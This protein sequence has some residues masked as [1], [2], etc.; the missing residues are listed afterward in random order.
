MKKF[1][2]ILGL[3]FLTAV[4]L[5][6]AVFLL[7]WKSPKYYVAK[8]SAPA[9]YLQF[10]NYKANH[11]KPYIIETNNL[12]IFGAEH[13]RDPKDS[14]IKPIKDKWERLQPTVALVEGRLGFLLPMFMDPVEKLGE[15]GK[16]KE[17]AD[18]DEIPLYNWDLSKEELAKKMESK[19][20]KEQIALAQ[21]LNPYFANQ[22]F[23]KPSDPE[24]FVSPYLKRAANVG[25]QNQITSAADIDRIWKKYFPTTDWRNVSD[26]YGLPGYLG[27]MMAVGNDF[28]NQQLIDVVK[29]LTAKGERVFVICG[30]SHAYCVAPALK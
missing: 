3:L 2:K 9:Q 23:G 25:L 11:T 20:S 30:S 22:R 4:V 27:E 17:L 7:A 16:V 26:E 18:R 13:T 5:G 8:S 24:G 1:F 14:Q 10:K 21:I 19:F 12:V 29:E 28:R 6:G 15:G